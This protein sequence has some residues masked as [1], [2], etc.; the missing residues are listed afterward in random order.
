MR[1]FGKLDCQ[2]ASKTL[3]RRVNAL[4]GAWRFLI[5]SSLLAVPVLGGGPFVAIAAAAVV[6]YGP[7]RIAR[8]ALRSWQA[9]GQ[10]A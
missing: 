2:D 3:V 9:D 10:T 6:I 4:L 7:L 5:W 8:I 1:S